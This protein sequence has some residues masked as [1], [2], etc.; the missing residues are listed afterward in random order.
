[1]ESRRLAFCF[2]NYK[3]SS[4]FQGYFHEWGFIL[5][6]NSQRKRPW[7]GSWFWLVRSLGS[8]R[9]RKQTTK[10]TTHF[11]DAAGSESSTCETLFN[12]GLD[13]AALGDCNVTVACNDDDNE[14]GKG[15]VVV[16]GSNRFVNWR[17]KFGWPWSSQALVVLEFNTW[18][19]RSA[20]QFLHLPKQNRGREEQPNPSRQNI[21][22]PKGVMLIASEAW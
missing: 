22:T 4:H 2:E 18:E 3:A 13:S 19:F 15:E 12:V 7:V 11:P 20:A 5:Y 8:C 21:Q 6:N 16:R 17:M 14:K 1:M 10:Y 9:V